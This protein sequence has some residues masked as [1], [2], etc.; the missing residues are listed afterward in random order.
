FDPTQEEREFT[1]KSYNQATEGLYNG[2]QGLERSNDLVQE[3][4][5]ETTLSSDPVLQIQQTDCRRAL[6]WNSRVGEG[7][8]SVKRS[9]RLKEKKWQ[10]LE[11]IGL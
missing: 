9:Q 8:D 6:K 4:I 11:V 3:E 7:E 10:K 1:F 5:Q 2:V